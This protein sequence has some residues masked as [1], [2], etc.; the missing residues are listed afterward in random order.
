MSTAQQKS[1]EAAITC[2]SYYKILAVSRL[3]DV[4]ETEESSY[5][6]RGEVS[7]TTEPAVTLAFSLLIGPLLSAFIIGIV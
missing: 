5:C 1:A 2:V 3:E 4:Y 7:A 6:F